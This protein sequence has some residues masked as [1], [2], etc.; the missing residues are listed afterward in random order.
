ME[1]EVT[2]KYSNGDVTVVWK[3]SLCIH[4]AMCIKG[5]PGVFN[6]EAHPW[7]N[8]NGA[9]T[10]EIIAQVNK[11]PSGALSY[12]RNDEMVEPTVEAETIVE[13]AANGPLLVYG[14]VRIKDAAGNQVVKHKVTAFCRCG[15]SQN[16]P[17]CD[18]A[19]KAA[20]F[21]G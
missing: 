9:S 3:N 1:R 14:N 7:I 12:Y 6:L 21:V 11:C 18:G 19:H 17:F 5:L 16:K 13:A 20:G 8:M 15:H 4:S 2:K 10:D